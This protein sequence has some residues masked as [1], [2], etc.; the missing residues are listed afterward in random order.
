MFDEEGDKFFGLIISPYYSITDLP[1]GINA[2]PQV[3]CFLNYKERE[4]DKLV[5]YE[6]TINII[7]QARFDNDKLMKIIADLKDNP[8]TVDK[9]QLNKES[10]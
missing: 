8:F 6:I 10:C 7:P 9:I 5:P 2:M 1:P 3:R 4:S